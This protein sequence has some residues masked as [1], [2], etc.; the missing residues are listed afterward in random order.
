M[1]DKKPTMSVRTHHRA[2][3]MVVMAVLASQSVAAIAAPAKDSLAELYE[4]AKAASVEVLVDGHL[5]GSGWFADD[6]GLAIT[7]AHVV[8]RPGRRVELLSPVM[9]RISAKVLA[10]DRG[11]DLALLQAEKPTDREAFP[12]LATAKR[13]PKAG[14]AIYLFGAPIYRHAVML[15]GR[16]A[17]N[18]TTFEYLGAKN[19]YVEVVHVAAT[20]QRGTSGGPWINHHGEVIGLQSGMM[21]RKTVP[22]GIAFVAP[23]EAIRRL[24]DR[25]Q[26]AATAALGATVE[27]LW[28]HRGDRLRHYPPRT[29]GLLVTS[30][31]KDGPA[32]K[33]GLKQW[34][35]ITAVGKQAVRTPRDL[36]QKIRA[37]SPGDKLR[38]K[39]L[40]P[41]NEGWR[42][43]VMTVGHLEAAWNAKKPSEKK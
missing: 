41:D 26:H 1:F 43:V 42:D 36:L 5:A 17:R 31:V 29:E 23:A 7:A 19:G 8:E 28:Q 4:K 34:D 12:A 9:G 11:H 24:Q 3:S 32:S 2:T 30:L 16:V 38:L 33:S 37:V 22:V 13:T 15:P 14:A 18:D 21:V 40:K 10:V 6:K 25:R 35:V 27:E 39:V 20:I